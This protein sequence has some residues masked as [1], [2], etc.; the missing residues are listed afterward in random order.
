MSKK[1]KA[2]KK[3]TT[4]SNNAS[5][6]T[7]K[8]RPSTKRPKPTKEEGLLVFYI[9]AAL[10]G[11]AFYW[12]INFV[13]GGYVDMNQVYK[14]SQRIQQQD[15]SLT[16]ADYDFY[17]KG[18]VYSQSKNFEWFHGYKWVNHTFIK[19]NRQNLQIM[20]TFDIDERYGA[21]LGA[22]FNYLRIIRDNTP[23]DAIIIMPDQSLSVPPPDA[24]PNSPKFTDV[25][26]KPASMYFLYP[27]TLI[28]DEQDRPLMEDGTAN[29]RADPDYEEKRKKATHV[30][31]MY[32]QG[33]EKLDYQVKQRQY[34]G[35]VPTKAPTS[36]TNDKNRPQ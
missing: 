5:Q 25:Y 13:I 33:Y 21:K 28:Y 23:E 4:K 1:K 34:Y 2:T 20:D 27:R 7:E 22:N 30:A 19:M 15:P 8:T 3:T 24:P 14:L 32:G 9:K 26:V 31:I 36:N 10:I 12:G 17:N 16:A 18:V 6:P 29:P 35:V 11:A